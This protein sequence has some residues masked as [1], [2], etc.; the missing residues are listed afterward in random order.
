MI[1]LVIMLLVVVSMLVI[2][3]VLVVRLLV[4]EPVALFLLP[5]FEL[6]PWA[7]ATS[8]RTLKLCQ[9]KV[10]ETGSLSMGLVL[11]NISIRN[12]NESTENC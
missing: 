11:E 8:A 5:A 3:F 10:P 6:C 4:L 7:Q 1:L 12:V 9:L 2:L